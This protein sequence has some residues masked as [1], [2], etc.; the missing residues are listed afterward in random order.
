[1]AQPLKLIPPNRAISETPKMISVGNAQNGGQN[2]SSDH[3]LS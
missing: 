3:S 1:M 2:I